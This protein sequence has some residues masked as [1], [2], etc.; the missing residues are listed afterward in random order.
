MHIL[1]RVISALLSA[2][3]LSAAAPPP[4]AQVDAFA[5]A[6]GNAKPL[7]VRIGRAIFATEW[8]AQI[9]N[10]YADGIGSHRVAGLRLSG[11]HFHRALTRAAFAG[12]VAEL[13]RRTFA[14]APVEEVDVWAAVPLAVSK[15]IVVSGDLAKPTSRTVFT[16]SVRRGE[17]TAEIVSRMNAGRGV[18]WDQEWARTAL[19]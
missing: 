19:K 14:A 8:S 2:A 7:A 13:V 11:V 16:I 9:L 18:F 15:G 6:S 10:V 4:V 1:R 12:E 3:L 17:P 5:R